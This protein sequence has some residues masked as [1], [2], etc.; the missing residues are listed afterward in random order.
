M[1]I[2]YGDDG[3]PFIDLGSGYKIRLENE[4]VTDE[5][6]IEKARTELRETTELKEESLKELRLLLQSKVEK[7]GFYFKLI[8]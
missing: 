4:E 1:S 8:Y 6:F 3:V 5:V 7:T 2:Q